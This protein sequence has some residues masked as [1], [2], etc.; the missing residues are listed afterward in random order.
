[1]LN[2][3]IQIL[4]I[5]CLCGSSLWAQQVITGRVVAQNTQAALPGVSVYFDGTTLGTIT[6]QQGEFKLERLEKT[7]LPLV[8][9]YLGYRTVT[10]SI[11]TQ[12]DTV[13]LGVISLEESAQNLQVVYLE[14]DPWSRQKKMEQFKRYFL[15]RNDAAESCKIMNPEVLHL[16]FQ[17]TA[18]QLVAYADA[19]LVIRN[20]YLGYKLTYILKDFYITYDPIETK[21]RIVYSPEMWFYSGLSRF[22]ELKK[23]VP[24]RF[25]R[26]RAEAYQGS[27]QHFMRALSHKQLEEEEFQ[28]YYKRLQRPAY[29]Y[30]KVSDTLDKTKVVLTQPKVSILYAM[31]YQTDF[32]LPK[33]EQKTV[34]Y[35]DDYGN[36]SP[37]DAFYMNGDM[38]R[39]GVAELLPL[40]YKL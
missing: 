22:E 5:L 27:M 23:R 14:N 17:P 31:Q 19:P 39:R 3:K 37:L 33:G 26:H 16:Q 24:K 30:F 15:G 35:I 9:D 40:N 20:T 10:K 28:V 21:S 18:K 2:F 8:I 7:S 32:S 25:I 12:S 1:M 6:N 4:V 38:G 34:F 36:F 29:T 11:Q 13:K